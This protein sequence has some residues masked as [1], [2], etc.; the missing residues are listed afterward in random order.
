MNPITLQ[1]KSSKAIAQ[2][3]SSWKSLRVESTGIRG[4]SFSGSTLL[5]SSN[6][7]QMHSCTGFLTWLSTPKT[8]WYFKLVH[9]RHSS[10]GGGAFHLNLQQHRISEGRITT[11]TFEFCW[12]QNIEKN[13]HV[14]SV[15]KREALRVT[16]WFTHM[17]GSASQSKMWIYIF[18]MYYVHSSH[19]R[20][21]RFLFSRTTNFLSS[22]RWQSAITFL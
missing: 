19:Q 12:K 13:L 15:I 14:S 3:K 8:K 9:K 1:F 10:C 6:F 17:A 22:R 18:Q 5:M 21:V 20:K 16:C 7:L 4:R 2:G 11:V